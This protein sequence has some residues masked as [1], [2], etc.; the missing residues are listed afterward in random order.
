[1][2]KG[3]AE[4]TQQNTERAIQATAV[5][6]DWMREIAEQS[7]HQ[8]K[9]S[10]DALF[11]ITRKAGD[12]F[13]QQASAVHRCSIGLA[14]ETFS[15][16]FELGQKM[17]RLKEPHDVIQAQSEFLSRQAEIVAALTKELTQNVAQQASGLTSATMRETAATMREASRKRAEAA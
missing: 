15:N 13:N 3:T 4:F 14:E 12:G 2:A 11:A 8:S 7:L 5:G 16:L 10:A 17:A 6:L 1:M 9:A